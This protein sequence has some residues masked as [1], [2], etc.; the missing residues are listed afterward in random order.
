MW[1]QGSMKGITGLIKDV[2]LM[3]HS[4]TNR[5]VSMQCVKTEAIQ[6]DHRPEKRNEGV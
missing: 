4:E 2:R 6:A 5:G 3:D 1:N